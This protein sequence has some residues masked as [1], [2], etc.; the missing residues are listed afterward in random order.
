MRSLL[1]IFISINI[2]S[3]CFSQ[4]D[5][6]STLGRATSQAAVDFDRYNNF[7]FNTK[8]GQSAYSCDISFVAAKPAYVYKDRAKNEYFF[9]QTLTSDSAAFNKWYTS[10]SRCLEK[11]KETWTP[12]NN[13]EER[14]VVFTCTETGVNIILRGES[15]GVSLEIS[16]PPMPVFA[17][18]FCEQ[19]EMLTN[20]AS[21]NFSGV[22]GKFRSKDTTL[23]FSSYYNSTVKLNQ[24]GDSG[25]ITVYAGPQGT[26]KP[27]Y[28]YGEIFRPKDMAYADI[29]AAFGNCL[30][31]AK[32]WKLEKQSM[33]GRERAVFKKG[34]A[35]VLLKTTGPGN[36]TSLDISMN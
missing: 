34:N 4:N 30:T 3:A 2:S 36:V 27:K 26:A 33:S 18:N 25:T 5:A 1:I 17:N 12:Y 9:L 35:V 23:M 31:E 21:K 28:F 13:N 7:Q 14:S 24:L 19:L 29:V 32:G 8:G 10:I 15:S 11:Q 6:C 22:T 20:E 16:G